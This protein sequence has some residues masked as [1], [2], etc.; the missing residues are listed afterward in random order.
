MST[1]CLLHGFAGQPSMWDALMAELGE[2][3]LCPLLPGHGAQPLCPEGGFFDAV[4]ALAAEIPSPVR[5]VGYSLGARLALGLLSRHAERVV[6]AL[7]VAVHPGL[8]DESARRERMRWDDDQAALLED[9]G[10]VAFVDGWERLPLFASQA[11]LPDEVLRKQRRERLGHRVEGLAWAMRTLGLGRMPSLWSELPRLGRRLRLVT[12]A[13]D[14]KFSAMAERIVASA[15]G[16][17]HR[18]IEGAGHNPALE[19][20]ALLARVIGA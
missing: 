12:G 8:E 2:P 20:P 5:L 1:L 14:A 16:A 17:E 3:A 11:A 19:Q 9:S 7:L 13:R 15:A 18:V 4:D 10:V 6:S